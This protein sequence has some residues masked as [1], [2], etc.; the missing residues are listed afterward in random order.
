[1]WDYVR[2]YSVVQGQ[3]KELR[4]RWREKLRNDTMEIDAARSFPVPAGHADLFFDYLRHRERDFKLATELLRTEEEALAF[5]E[6]IQR[7]AR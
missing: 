4:E 3:R 2:F 6:R 1:L 7:L 5:C